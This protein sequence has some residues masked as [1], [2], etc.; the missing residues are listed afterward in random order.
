MPGIHR[1]EHVKR[2][3]IPALSHNDPVRAHPQRV[4]QQIPDCD[5][6]AKI[7]CPRLKRD[8]I[9]G[10]AD[11]FF[12]FCGLGNLELA[13]ILNRHDAL[14]IGNDQSQRIEQ[15]GLSCAGSA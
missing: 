6:R 10:A 8:Q 11:V 3:A 2:C 12:L 14:V 13:R 4:A 7:L 5:G 9:A 15:S 1:L